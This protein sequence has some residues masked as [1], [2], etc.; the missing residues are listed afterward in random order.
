MAP[1]TTAR[2]EQ[3]KIDGVKATADYV[4]ATGAAIGRIAMLRE[5]RIARD[6]VIITA[7]SK[8]PAQKAKTL[9]QKTVKTRK[10]V[11]SALQWSKA[12]AKV[13]ADTFS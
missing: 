11:L 4:E 5:A 2:K 12:V 3:A 6:A 10:R 9:E 8:P 1:I 13:R 7:P